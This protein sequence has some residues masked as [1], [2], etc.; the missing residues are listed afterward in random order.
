MRS[1]HALGLVLAA[2]AAV[3]CAAPDG[4][5]RVAPL[6][7]VPGGTEIYTQVGT[8]GGLEEIVDPAYHMANA[9]RS[10]ESGRTHGAA[11]ELE[12]L[13]AFLR[14]EADSAVGDRRDA[15]ETSHGEIEQLALRVRRGEVESSALLESA[16][17]RARAA[18]R[19]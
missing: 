12:K 10:F 19:R 13:A 14:Y 5:E 7:T 8:S 15:L 11:D 1:S 17:A 4:G 3:A 2:G 18:M 16:F 9:R 6:P